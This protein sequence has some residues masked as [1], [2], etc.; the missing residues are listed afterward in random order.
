M[1]CQHDTC[2]CLVIDRGGFCSE[3]CRIVG[4]ETV[5]CPCGHVECEGAIRAGGPVQI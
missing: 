4:E 2:T 5:H 1:H 3:A